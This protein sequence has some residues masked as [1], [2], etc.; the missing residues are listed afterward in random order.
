MPSTDAD[1][2]TMVL[3]SAVV[4]VVRGLEP[5]GP[6]PPPNRVFAEPGA[7]TPIFNS[8]P[9]CPLASG[10]WSAH[11][12]GGGRVLRA[13]ARRAG[14]DRRVTGV[15]GPRV[16]VAAAV[17]AAVALAAAVAVLARVV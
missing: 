5:E 4:S 17:V 7:S 15:G 8:A 9:S 6:V 14:H 3:P 11:G 13:A 10:A 2:S 1:S 16:G 12:R